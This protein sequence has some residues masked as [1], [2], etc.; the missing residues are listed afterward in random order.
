VEV[1]AYRERLARL[2]S[3]A[4]G[5]LV[6]ERYGEA[7]EQMGE[8]WPV[9]SDGPHPVAVLVHGGF[10]RS[11]YRLDLMHALAADLQRRGVAGWNLEYRRVGSAGG[12]WP[13]TFDDVAAGF[14]ALGDLAGGYDLDLGRVAVV[15]HSAGGHLALWLAGRPRLDGGPG[16]RPRLEPA[17][18][19]ALAGVCDLVEAARR[20][21]SQDAVVDLLGGGPRERPEAYLRGSPA[22]LLPLGVPQVLVHGTADESVPFDISERYAAAA[23]TAGDTC[24]LIVL[25]GVDHFALIDPA[26]PAWQ[27][28]VERL[29]QALRLDSSSKSQWPR[30]PG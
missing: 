21:L 16:V 6:V 24:E 29:G 27:A 30:D 20:H 3:T 13:G 15:G 28:T 2:T 18:A 8:L 7:A 11:R 1:E 12:G 19:V 4:G 9:R 22:A 14:D 17:L 5:E 26:S 23:R 10:W 25:E